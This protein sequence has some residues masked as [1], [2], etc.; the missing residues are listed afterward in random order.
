M[1]IS[2]WIVVYLFFH[3]L[4]V[5]VFF[6]IQIQ[7]SHENINYFAEQHLL[8][9]QEFFQTALR[10]KSDVIKKIILDYTF[11][12]EMYDFV[13]NKNANWAKYNLDTLFKSINI[14]FLWV[15]D[16]NEKKVYFT[17]LS[18]ETEASDLQNLAGFLKGEMKAY[19]STNRYIELFIHYKNAHYQ[20]FGST[21]HPTVD[22]ERITSPSGYLFVAKKW[23]DV[24]MDNIK[25]IV[26]ADAIEFIDGEY[27]N[28]PYDF[29]RLGPKLVANIPLP[30]WKLS[31]YVKVTYIDNAVI[32]YGNK[33]FGQ[34]FIVGFLLAVSYIAFFIILLYRIVFPLRKISISLETRSTDQIKSISE[35]KSEF[36]DISRMINDFFIQQQNAEIMNTQLQTA[37]A[38]Q[39]AMLDN[40]P[41]MIW[42]K[43]K[44]G[45]FI[46]INKA[47]EKFFLLTRDQV[48]GK[49]NS[50]VFPPEIA[51]QFDDYLEKIF[52]CR[53]QLSYEE[54]I[55]L[56]D[57]T[58][59]LE[60]FLTPIFS[61]NG[62][63]IGVTGLAHDI[64]M[65]KINEE[66]RESLQVQLYQ[67]N[68][69]DT[70]GKL[71]GGVAHEFRN[72]LT[73]IRGYSDLIQYRPKKDPEL[74]EYLKHIIDA[75]DKATS[76]TS[77]LLAFS[78]KQIISPYNINLNDQLYELQKVIQPLIGENIK[79]VF[80]PHPHLSG[81]FADKAQIEQIVFNL[82]LNSKD[83]M[84]DGGNIIWSTDNVRIDDEYCRKNPFAL[85]GNYIRFSVADKGIGMEEAVL[86]KVFDPFFTTKDAGKGTGMGLAVVH[87][88]VK[89]HNG[90]VTAESKPGKG[91]VFSVY[92]PVMDDI[93]S[94]GSLSQETKNFTQLMGNLE[95]ILYIEDERSVRNLVTETLKRNKYLVID[96]KDIK[97]ARQ[98]LDE[99][100][101]GIQLIISDILLP[102]GNGLEFMQ[103]VHAAY[104]GIP[105]IL[106]SG[107]ADSIIRVDSIERQG[108]KFVPKPFTLMELL[109]RVSEKI[110][111]NLK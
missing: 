17:S 20:L 55:L 4:L 101:A 83:A 24:L 36:G 85:S 86:K 80:K 52:Q 43:D 72:Y 15:Y 48:I 61:Q 97:T 87:G 103:E 53:K 84:P 32:E 79:I 65:Q 40:I 57:K 5:T 9:K 2:W 30:G 14:H 107:Y 3:L 109:R 44:D 56:H 62:E 27:T 102:D 28:E 92:L 75:A 38:H 70:L 89:Q 54:E 33:L 90:W 16:V 22:F 108:F 12:D 69:I 58:V 37:E 29:L 76:I 7:Y 67:L 82:T 77:Q 18:N 59:F 47:F 35:A 60:K 110:N 105:I 78:R 100:K 111:E 99:N 25:S 95:Q 73:V 88:I 68:K 39:K 1:K 10:L 23:D 66:E 26:Y 106:T 6:S 46:E 104:P 34:L 45:R 50:E 98:K 8:E 51:S 31:H 19:F 11:W 81:I 96:C 94:G 13:R 42:L 71:A 41:Y 91:S 49:T 21:I 63:L 74:Q 64:T 93:I